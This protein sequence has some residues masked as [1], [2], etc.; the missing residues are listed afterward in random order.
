MDPAPVIAIALN[1]LKIYGSVEFD[2]RYI[3]VI[4]RISFAVDL[5]FVIQSS[6]YN[7]N[8]TVRAGVFGLQL[9]YADIVCIGQPVV[10]SYQIYGIKVRG[11]SRRKKVSPDNV[12]FFWYQTVCQ[13]LVI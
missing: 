2:L 12:S 4:C 3:L 1:G 11:H 9:L 13:R 7:E 10:L 6:I 8:I 5:R